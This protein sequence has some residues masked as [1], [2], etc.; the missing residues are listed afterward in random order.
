[1]LLNP[2]QSKRIDA[3][4][5]FTY[6]FKLDQILKFHDTFGKAADAKALQVSS[7]RNGACP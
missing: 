1:M 5:L 3:G 4:R 6:H 7:K 2:M